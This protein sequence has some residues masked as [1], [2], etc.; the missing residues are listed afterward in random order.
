MAHWYYFL[1]SGGGLLPD[2][3]FASSFRPMGTKRYLDTLR[4]ASAFVASPLR[5][6]DLPSAWNGVLRV[7]LEMDILKNKNAWSMK[8]GNIRAFPQKEDLKDIERKNTEQT[9]GR[10]D[11][12]LVLFL[13]KRREGRTA[14]RYELQRAGSA[15]EN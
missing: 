8:N 2:K 1:E 11:G 7:A 15:G 3:G 6:R 12:A 4:S 13:R 5:L 14:V 10:A 9:Q